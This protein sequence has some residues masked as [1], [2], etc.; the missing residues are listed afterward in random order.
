MNH[1][2]YDYL[3]IGQGLA[4]SVLAV[5]LI[6]RGKR[7]LVLD[8]P[9]ANMCSTVA[10]GIFNPVTTGRA[11]K[12]TWRAPELF[13]SLDAF[14][15]E[16]EVL[17]KS[18]FLY[19]KTIYRPFETIAEQNEWMAADMK[20]KMFVGKVETHPVF[21][22]YI[23]NPFGGLVLKNGGYLNVRRFLSA[24]REYLMELNAFVSERF[25]ESE[26]KIAG[27]G[28]QYRN[29]SASRVVF[30]QGFQ[31][32]ESRYFSWVPIRTLKGEVLTIQADLPDDVIFN[33]G[34]YLVP[35][36]SGTWKAGATYSHDTNPG[37]SADG[38]AELERRIANMLK[39]PYAVTGQSWGFRPTTPD[40]K[41]I[42]GI[43]PE[44]HRLGF[45]N[46]LGTKGVSLAPYFAG[47]LISALENGVPVDKEVD[48][49][50]YNVLY[51]KSS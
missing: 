21:D 19:Q 39:I 14:Y 46:G 18:K 40:R 26:M 32:L 30:C 37:T 17:T 9:E 20:S 2:P 10:A 47:V 43:H 25:E 8:Q 4:G 48:I 13:S 36:G 16:A 33:R 11:M 23:T 27:E 1:H 44:F 3:I 5:Q 41:P 28:V 34:V 29:L 35:D 7:V 42:L 50:R 38:R 31:S 6:G 49:G 22:Q 51:C 24:V 15:R 12:Q 45:F